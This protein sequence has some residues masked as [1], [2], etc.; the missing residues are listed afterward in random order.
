[1]SV[2]LHSR[3]S[4]G[5][6]NQVSVTARPGNINKLIVSNSSASIRYMH[7][8]NLATAPTAGSG[9][10]VARFLIPGNAS[11]TVLSLNLGSYGGE[12]TF[13]SGIGY[14]ITTGYADADTGAIGAG[15]VIINMEYY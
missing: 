14:T 7:L 13:T 15:E 8:Y 2:S 9:T 4:T 6:T 5:D 3:I 10:P 12:D 11:G 1:M